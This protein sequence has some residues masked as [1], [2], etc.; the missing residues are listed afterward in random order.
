MNLMN[1]QL[2]LTKRSTSI[3]RLKMRGCV[4]CDIPTDNCDNCDNC[5]IPT[6]A[7]QWIVTWD[8]IQPKGGVLLEKNIIVSAFIGARAQ[9]IYEETLDW[10]SHL[11]L[12]GM[13]DKWE[14]NI[15]D[16]VSSFSLE[17]KRTRRAASDSLRCA[18]LCAMP[19]LEYL[20]AIRNSQF[21][22]RHMKNYTFTFDHGHISMFII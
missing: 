5:D 9:A 13:Q 2:T 22:Q 7:T 18:Q 6:N 3:L 16:W 8:G 21:E 20:R 12:F 14:K 17:W 1:R 4:I 10:L 11:F 19:S 15:Q